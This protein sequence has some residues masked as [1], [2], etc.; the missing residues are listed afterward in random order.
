VRRD[1]FIGAEKAHDPV[2]VLC[3]ALG[4]SRAGFYAWKQRGLSAR[5]QADAR[6]TAEIRQVYVRSRH[7]YG[8]PRI[9]ADLAAR[10]LAV[11]RK[12]VARL[13]RTAQFVGCCR[14]RRAVR[15]TVTDPTATAAPNVIRR[16]FAP[17]A[18]N[19]LW[20]GDITSVPT[21]EGWL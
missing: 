13:M 6:L 15:T 11:G 19:R 12:R 4:V 10:G 16:D 18:P 20:V 3:R 21:D 2:T 1:R 8:A 17:A 14:R 9:H 5:A 7:T